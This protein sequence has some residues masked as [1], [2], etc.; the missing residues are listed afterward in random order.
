MSGEFRRN[1]SFRLIFAPFYLPS[2]ITPFSLLLGGFSLHSFIGRFPLTPEL[3]V[4]CLDVV[5]FVFI[6][7]FNSFMSHKKNTKLRIFAMFSLAI[8]N[9]FIDIFKPNFLLMQ[10]FHHHNENLKVIESQKKSHSLTILKRLT[11][12]QI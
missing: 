6:L 7:N 9:S 12:Y 5:R 11:F 10:N 3:S 2:V 8:F 4:T 1:K